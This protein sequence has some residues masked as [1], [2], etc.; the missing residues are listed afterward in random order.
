MNLA[1]AIAWAKTN[2]QGVLLGLGLGMAVCAAKGVL[3]PSG[4]LQVEASAGAA[5]SL[6][7]TA[8][9]HSGGSVTV[10]GRPAMPCPADKVCPEVQPVRIVYDCGATVS[11]HGES[12]VSATAK[13]L[14]VPHGTLWGVTFGGGREIIGGEAWH[15]KLALNYGALSAGVNC[16][17][18]G[19]LAAEAAWTH[20][21]KGP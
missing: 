2:W 12:A 17:T 16:N 3:S 13:I 19:K 14:D 1:L 6:S 10:P 7:G 9:A 5:T 4:P 8:S 11:G 15:G 21:F 20:W 18:E